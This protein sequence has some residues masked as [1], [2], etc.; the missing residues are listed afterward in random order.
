[1]LAQGLR[2]LSPAGEGVATFPPF[3]AGGIEKAKGSLTKSSA[4]SK[5]WNIFEQLRRTG[6]KG[7]EEAWGLPLFKPHHASASLRD[8]T[9]KTDQHKAVGNL[10]LDEQ[11]NQ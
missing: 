2:K 9:A 10:Q 7:R 1:M 5:T 3:W 4:V 6:Q 8:V 11:F